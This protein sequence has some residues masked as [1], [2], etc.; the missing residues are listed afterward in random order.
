VLVQSALG[1]TA[2]IPAAA[3]MVCNGVTPQEPNGVDDLTVRI[4]AVLVAACQT[5]RIAPA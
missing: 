2:G 5:R 1:I 3:K 4:D